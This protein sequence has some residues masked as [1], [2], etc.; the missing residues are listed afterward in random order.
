MNSKTFKQSRSIGLFSCQRGDKSIFSQS[1]L[2][3][4][5]FRSVDVGFLGKMSEDMMHVK[6]D[7]DDV[8]I[9][10]ESDDLNGDNAQDD[11]NLDQQDDLYDSV[12]TS[13][14]G[15]N[16]TKADRS[17]ESPHSYP[18]FQGNADVNL[19]NPRRDMKRTCYI[20]NM[21]WWT[22][23]QEL[24]DAVLSLGISDLHDLK[25]YEN[26]LN[27]QSKGFAIVTL[28]SEKS[29]RQCMDQISTKELHGQK[30]VAL[31]Y[32][33]THLAQLEAA[34]KR[35]EPPMRK[36]DRETMISQQKGPPQPAFLGTVRIGSAAPAAPS[37]F[38]PRPAIA[39][40]AVIGS[41]GFSGPAFPPRPMMPTGAYP[42]PQRPIVVTGF[43]GGPGGPIPGR[44]P[45]PMPPATGAPP[46]GVGAPAGA[47]I[48]PNFYPHA[49]A[50]A[51][52]A[53]GGSYPAPP[54]PAPIEQLSP[55]EFEEILNRN[56]T[57]SSSAISRAVSDAAAGDF[58]SSIETLVTA[59][60]LIRQSKVAHD[61][62]C[63]V[64]I[65]SLQ[66]TLH[67]IEAK[68]YGGKRR[69]SRSHSRDRESSRSRHKR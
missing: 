19:F 4:F 8:D 59:I 49:A 11:E 62:R 17:S 12:L 18:T 52:A 67:G 69:R 9:Y 36:R 29:L 22:N 38:A 63:K 43:P 50:A 13:G 15:N 41:A 24:T 23:D 1:I 39:Q 16:G 35:P 34:T 3:R 2:Y 40:S 30:L 51:A 47:H 10:G 53:A 25:F 14:S 45:H 65:A 56:K 6:A 26:R 46:P 44:L 37:L 66:D 21:T 60:S 20:G 33:K 68:S 28:G 54:A 32:T 61:D 42:Q 48:N 27:G 58:A 57:V 31:P 55:E 5:E 64:L 7:A